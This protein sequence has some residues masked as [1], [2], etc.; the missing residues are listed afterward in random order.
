MLRVSNYIM[1]YGN[2]T[3][4]PLS[5][6]RRLEHQL[7]VLRA[8]NLA[9]ARLE[10]GRNDICDGASWPTASSNRGQVRNGNLPNPCNVGIGQNSLNP[11][12]VEKT[13]D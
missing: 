6:A 9:R 5:Y 11:Q 8:A 7:S 2:Y 13:N 4:D 1:S 3:D 10:D 12:Y